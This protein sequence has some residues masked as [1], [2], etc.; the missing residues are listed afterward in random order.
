V[1]TLENGPYGTYLIVNNDGRDILVQVDYDYPSL[2]DSFG[3]GEF[4]GE[5]DISDQIAKATEWLDDH[6][7]AKAEDPGYFSN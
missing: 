1:I 5:E 3:W 6:I 4:N 2:A 7:G